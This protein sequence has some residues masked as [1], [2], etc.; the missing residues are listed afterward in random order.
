MSRK[1]QFQPP[2]ANPLTQNINTLPRWLTADRDGQ[3]RREPAGGKGGKKRM[4]ALTMSL[5]WVIQSTA[6]ESLAE[7]CAVTVVC[8][9][10]SQ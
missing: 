4:A 8:H 7:P 1:L 6:L 2:R 5:F 9:S 3:K 10:L